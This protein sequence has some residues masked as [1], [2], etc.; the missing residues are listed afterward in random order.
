MHYILPANFK[1]TSWLDADY[2]SRLNWQ[3]YF[4]QPVKVLPVDG[5]R[6][7]VDNA[8]HLRKVFLAC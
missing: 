6:R 7:D 2:A 8:I 3:V 4:R 5:L 1:R